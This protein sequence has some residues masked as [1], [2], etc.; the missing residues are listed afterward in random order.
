MLQDRASYPGWP[1]VRYHYMCVTDRPSINQ[2]F[3]KFYIRPWMAGNNLA[4]YLPSVAGPYILQLVPNKY[5]L[6]VPITIFIELFVA[7]LYLGNTNWPQLRQL[8]CYSFHCQ[9][10]LFEAM[11]DFV[12]LSFLEKLQYL[13]SGTRRRAKEIFTLGMKDR[14][15][16]KLSW[17]AINDCTLAS[18]C[19]MVFIPALTPP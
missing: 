5:G 18:L 13:P 15:L 4:I 17:Q 10:G 19:Y 7:D 1:R 2:A 12:V 6:C 16:D 8:A 14:N 9:W 3:Q 11:T